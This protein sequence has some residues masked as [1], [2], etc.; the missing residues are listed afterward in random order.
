MEQHRKVLLIIHAPEVFETVKSLLRGMPVE[1]DRIRNGSGAVTLAR[2]AR[3]DVILAEYPLPDLQLDDLLRHLRRPNSPLKATPL[4]LL[5]TSSETELVNDRPATDLV[6]LI[7]LDQSPTQ[8]QQAV[9]GVLGVALRSAT[10]LLVQLQLELH[11]KP[12][13]RVCQCKNVSDSGLLLHTSRLLPIGT[14]L[15]LSF[16]LPQDP[17]EITAVAR[18]VRHTQL[19]KEGLAGM[20]MAFVRMDSEMRER[21][22]EYLTQE[23]QPAPRDQEAASTEPAA[24]AD[25]AAD[26]SPPAGGRGE[27]R[28]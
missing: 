20:G 7:S 22:R 26:V 12:L 10:R 11:G 6:Q 9:S 18:V 1:A 28:P 14:E 15:P 16:S 19:S 24:E 2:K 23:Q 5:S 21:L 27:I 4:V 8:L 17:R 25:T 3:Y 13:A